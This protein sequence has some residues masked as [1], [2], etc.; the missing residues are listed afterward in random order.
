MEGVTDNGRERGD[1]SKDVK[2][3]T[4]ISNK[5]GKQVTDRKEMLRVWEEY[6][7]TLLNQREKRTSAVEGKLRVGK[8]GV[9][10]IEREQ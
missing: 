8:I 10:E 5:N 1:V 3:G 6:F 2:G 9:D 7:N 4:V